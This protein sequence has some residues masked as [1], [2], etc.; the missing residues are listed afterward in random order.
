MQF[1]TGF[2]LHTFPE[3]IE[4]EPI[5]KEWYDDPW[6]DTSIVMRVLMVALAVIGYK[7]ALFFQTS[8][9][10][11]VSAV[12]LVGAAQPRIFFA[13]SL[14][15]LH[16]PADEPEESQLLEVAE[17]LPPFPAVEAAALDVKGYP[18][19]PENRLLL[20]GRGVFLIPP[21]R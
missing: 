21:M 10:F 17:E 11:I 15:A 4:A 6:S 2:A 19:F 3:P 14:S 9:F 20:A 16:E 5:K 12:A 18:Y 13:G 7:A 1:P 8:A